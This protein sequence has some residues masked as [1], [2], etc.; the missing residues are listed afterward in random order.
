MRFTPPYSCVLNPTETYWA[1]VKNKWRKEMAKIKVAYDHGCLEADIDIICSAVA[2]HLDENIL[3]VID[4]YIK[5]VGLGQL[6]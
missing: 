4:P 5:K 6:V 1:L 3:T 2:E